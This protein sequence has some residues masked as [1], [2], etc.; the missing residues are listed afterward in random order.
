MKQVLVLLTFLVVINV[1]KVYAIY[2]FLH[3]VLVIINV[4]VDSVT[5]LTFIIVN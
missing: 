1:I 4:T 3:M 2:I 5:V